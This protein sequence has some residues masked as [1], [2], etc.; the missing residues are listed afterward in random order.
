MPCLCGERVCERPRPLPLLRLAPVTTP[1]AA[2]EQPEPRYDPN[3]SD[4]ERQRQVSVACPWSS[5]A[6]RGVVQRHRGE[7]AADG[8][9]SGPVSSYPASRAS[10][11]PRA[12]SWPSSRR[13][14]ILR[15][16]TV[17]PSLRV[18]GAFVVSVRPSEETP[19]GCTAATNGP[20][21]VP[22][23]G[24]PHVGP[25]ARARARA[26]A[27]S[28]PLSR[29]R[30]SPR[31]GRLRSGVEPSPAR[32]PCAGSG[33]ANRAEESRQASIEPG[34]SES[35]PRPQHATGAGRSVRE[36][37]APRWGNT[38]PDASSETAGW[39]VSGFRATAP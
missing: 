32:A 3:I 21:E 2:Q 18:R 20:H 12:R 6:G 24:N 10:S 30:H 22:A 33:E 17:Q 16:G 8:G 9:G 29:S 39:S 38:P 15:V 35:Q 13:S 1:K 26:G 14:R 31:C 5:L 28:L 7:E 36:R 25:S 27:M 4:S 19:E 34:V 37:E 23:R 11:E